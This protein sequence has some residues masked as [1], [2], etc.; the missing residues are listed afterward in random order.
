MTALRK[1]AA[2]L[3][4][5]ALPGCALFTD[6]ATPA[7]EAVQAQESI[8]LGQST[9]F[10]TVVQQ[11]GGLDEADRA[12]MLAAINKDRADYLELSGELRAWLEEL[13]SVD[14]AHV[15]KRGYEAWLGTQK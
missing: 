8:F 7:L 12:R 14:W 15:A 1:W 3:A 6:D 10:E 13:G 2:V 5:L 9:A 4:L 11:A